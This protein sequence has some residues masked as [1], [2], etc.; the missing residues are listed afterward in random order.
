[1]TG[2][3]YAIGDIHGR[4]DLLRRAIDAIESHAA[5]RDHAVI[6]L[7]DYVDRGPESRGVDMPARQ[8]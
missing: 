4:L 2:F 7:G 3:T 5:G 6:C 8:P 1:M